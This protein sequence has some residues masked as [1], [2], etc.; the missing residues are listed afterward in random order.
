MILFDLA[1]I[2]DKYLQFKFCCSRKFSYESGLWGATLSPYNGAPMKVRSLLLNILFLSIFILNPLSGAAQNSASDSALADLGQRVKMQTLSNGMRVIM[3]KRG[4]A[5]VFSGAVVVRVGG[6]DEQMGETGISHMFEHMAF[7]GTSRLGTKDYAREKKLLAQLESI[8]VTLKNGAAPNEQQAK[9]LTRINSEL[10]QVWEAEAF[11]NEYKRNGA[12][13]MNATTESEFTKYMVSLPRAAF[14]LW[15]WM[16]SERLLDPVMRQFYKERDVVMEERRMRNDDSPEGS[17]Y[18]LL[19][20]T[21]FTV[22]PYRFPVIGY[23]FDLTNLTATDLE[24][25]RKKFYVPSNIVLGL[26]GDVDMERDLAMVERYFG[27]MNAGPPPPRPAIVEPPQEG[28]RE[29][30]LEKPVNP[31]IGIAYRRPPY[32]DPDDPALGLLE[33]IV[34]GGRLSPLYRELVINKQIATSV[35]SHTGPGDGYPGFLMFWGELKSPHTNDEFLENF[36]Q[37]INKIKK[38]GVSSEDMEIA[39]RSISMN[40][41]GQLRDNMSMALNL[42]TVELLYPEGWRAMTHWYDLVMKVSADDVKRVAQKYLNDSTRTIGRIETKKEV[43]GP[44][45]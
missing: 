18:E 32:P 45:A 1:G 29:V 33:E 13:G 14:E 27:R 43:G 9:E 36:D 10:N 28:R 3:L 4:A 44:N 41:L 17:L 34:A 35:G 24:S 38:D 23:K 5:P 12:S 26:V 40:Y 19:L 2:I 6:V 30:R 39:R 21:M 16:E 37:V 15:C 11:V 31:Q 42:A 22:H 25:F 7:K 20:G 8:M